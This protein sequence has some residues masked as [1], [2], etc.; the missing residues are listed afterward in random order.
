MNV[1]A[2]VIGVQV[3]DTVLLH[4]TFGEFTESARGRIERNAIALLS[5]MRAPAADPPSANSL[6][7]AQRSRAGTG[8]PPAAGQRGPR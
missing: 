1:D 2:S 7:G 6:G 5:H 4:H 3:L 8:V